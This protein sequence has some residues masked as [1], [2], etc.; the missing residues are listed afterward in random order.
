M[1]EEYLQLG[2]IPSDFEQVLMREFVPYSVGLARVSQDDHKTFT[3]LGSGTL[4]K[5]GARIGV[6][7]AQHCLTACSPRIR[8]G[9]K[10]KDP[11]LLILRDARGV[12]LPRAGMIEHQL[13]SPLTAEYGPDLVFH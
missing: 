12:Q 2:D 1:T 6:L 7:T 3:P 10:G 13:V 11:L 9:P 4:V 8:V 5:K